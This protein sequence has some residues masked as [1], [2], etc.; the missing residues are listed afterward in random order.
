MQSLQAKTVT[1]HDGQRPVV[2]SNARFKVVNAG[3]RWGKTK[4]AVKLMI[5]AARA[6]DGPRNPQADRLVWWVAPTYKVVKR[7][8]R[9]CKRQLPRELLT[10]DFPP[11]TN[12]DAGR[13]VILHL[14]SGA[15]IEFYSA[16]RPGGMLGEGV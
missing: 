3:R 4:I 11:E 1:P 12:F 5:D 9:E 14:K 15:S 8:Y 2:E 6:P 16:E 7:G 10:H 13:S